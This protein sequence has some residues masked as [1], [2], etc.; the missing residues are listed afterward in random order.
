V[1]FTVADKTGIFQIKGAPSEPLQ[2]N[3]RAKHNATAFLNAIPFDEALALY[4]AN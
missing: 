3:L 4:V 2:A 1:L